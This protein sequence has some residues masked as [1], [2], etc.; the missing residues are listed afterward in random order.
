MKTKSRFAVRGLNFLKLIIG[1]SAYSLAMDLFLVGNDIAAGGVG[2][3][4]VVICK[5]VPLSI[6]TVTLLLNMPIML[7]SLHINGFKYTLEAFVGAVLTSV[8]VDLFSFLPCFTSDPLV[9]SVFGGALYGFGMAMLTRCGGSNGGTDL[10]NRSLLKIFPSMSIGRMS[11]ILDGSVVLLA[12]IV[13]RGIDVGLYAI[14]TLFVCSIIC[15]SILLGYDKGVISLVVTAM[16]PETV[17]KP[18]MEL[19]GRG[20]TNLRGTGMYSGADRNVLMLAVKPK[21]IHKV[22][23][24]L[25]KTDP[26]AFVMLITANELIGGQFRE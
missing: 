3:I 12:M 14:I 4:A 18:L 5:F 17:A 1:I 7:F 19:T 25:N 21:E 20:V 23:E 15:D 26:E 6:G 10:L 24:V 13:F 11:M 8:L 2:G 16:D 9:A 22:K